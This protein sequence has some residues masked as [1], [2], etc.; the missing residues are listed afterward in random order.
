[1]TG[2]INKKQYE[3]AKQVGIKKMIKT[4][5][6]LYNTLCQKCKAKVINN[7]KLNQ[8]EYCLVCRKVVEEKLKEFDK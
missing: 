5:T 6:L 3:I 4:F 8:K 7:P 1:M 2:K